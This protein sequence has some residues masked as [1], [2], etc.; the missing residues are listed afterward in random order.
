MLAWEGRGVLILDDFHVIQDRFILHV[1][2]KLI[3]SLPQ[4]LQVVLLTREDPPL[5]LA[6]L[7]ANNQLTEIR[8]S[9]L[10]FSDSRSRSSF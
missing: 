5:P 1:L 4:S 8:A 2:E 3:T 7:R 9:D 10:R 6:R